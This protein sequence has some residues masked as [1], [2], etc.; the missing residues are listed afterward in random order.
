MNGRANEGKKKINCG[1]A[2]GE[3]RK[4]MKL[5]TMPRNI[6]FYKNYKN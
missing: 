6:L 5:S 2:D 3:R 4:N 1:H